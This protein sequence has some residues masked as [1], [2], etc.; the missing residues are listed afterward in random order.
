[1]EGPP[2]PP[3]P[4]SEEGR[5][6]LLEALDLGGNGIGADALKS[7]PSILK[8]CPLLT[9]LTLLGNPLGSAGAAVVVEALLAS[10]S[11]RCLDLGHCELG[12]G[13]RD[14]FEILYGLESVIVSQG[15]PCR[16]S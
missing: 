16:R 3:P 1:M 8:S 12:P 7:L 4:V 2:P 5:C 13:N 11:V 6:C 10:A 15:W 14:T 9:S